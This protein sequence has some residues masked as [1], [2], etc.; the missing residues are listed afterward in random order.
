MSFLHK[1]SRPFSRPQIKARLRNSRSRESEPCA[2]NVLALMGTLAVSLMVAPL[3][4]QDVMKDV[5]LQA[6]F[7]GQIGMRLLRQVIR[8]GFSYAILTWN[9]CI[10][11]SILV[12]Y[13]CPSVSVVVEASLVL[14]ATM[15]CTSL[16]MR[17]CHPELRHLWECQCETSASRLSILKLGSMSGPR[18]QNQPDRA[19]CFRRVRHQSCCSSWQ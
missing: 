13:A 8:G 2:R 14:E 17:F 18:S 11:V 7:R 6:L 19:L 16:R 3:A 12:F 10:C 1:A 4:A 5:C 15:T 9:I